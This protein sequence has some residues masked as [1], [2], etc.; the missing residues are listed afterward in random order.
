MKNELVGLREDYKKVQELK[1]SL[2]LVRV[3]SSSVEASIDDMIVEY[4]NILEA[5]E[6]TEIMRL[7]LSTGTYMLDVHYIIAESDEDIAELIEDDFHA[8]AS[9]Y[10]TYTQQEVDHMVAEYDAVKDEEFYYVDLGL[11][12]DNIVRVEYV[13]FYEWLNMDL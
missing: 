7:C 11:Y 2:E 13:T 6:K 3:S 8:N 1:N 12:I 4:E 9:S 5:I 10:R